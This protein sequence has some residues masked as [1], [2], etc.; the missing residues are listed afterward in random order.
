MPWVRPRHWR[1]LLCTYCPPLLPLAIAWDGLASTLRTYR[2]AELQQLVATLPRTAYV[3]EVIELTGGALPVLAVL[4]RPQT[5][6]GIP[7]SSADVF[8]INHRCPH[9]TV[10]GRTPDHAY[11]TARPNSSVVTPAPV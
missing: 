7:S 5:S 11:R 8:F 10:A 9:T 3:W 6:S 1:A 4:G 2:V